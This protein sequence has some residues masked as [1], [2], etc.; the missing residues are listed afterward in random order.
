MKT[1]GYFGNLSKNFTN[2]MKILDDKNRNVFL[3]NHCYKF[4]LATSNTL[5]LKNSF[6]IFYTL[7]SQF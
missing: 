4:V 1:Y 7:A 6:K 3:Q 2:A 5:N